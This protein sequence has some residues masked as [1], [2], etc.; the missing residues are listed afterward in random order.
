M[1]CC[2]QRLTLGVLVLVGAELGL[3]GE[4]LVLAP[5]WSPAHGWKRRALLKAA[6]PAARRL[7]WPKH[8]AGL[9]GAAGFVS[10]SDAEGVLR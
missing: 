9:A 10:T 3:Q 4:T 2:E 8:K 5:G 1:S 7:L 6:F